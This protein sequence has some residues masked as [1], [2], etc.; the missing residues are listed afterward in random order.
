MMLSL[1]KH[2]R[3]S[4]ILLI[5]TI[6]LAFFRL[7]SFFFFAFIVSV[8]TVCIGILLFDYIIFDGAPVNGLSDS[9]VVAKKVDKTIVVCSTN[10]TT[11]DELSKAVKSLGTIDAK[12]AGVVL[13]RV[14]DKKNKKYGYYTNSYYTEAI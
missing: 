7:S 10:T 4:E 13:N 5:L 8:T 3:R 11:I 6:P 12:V 14:V 9:L 2:V 1:R